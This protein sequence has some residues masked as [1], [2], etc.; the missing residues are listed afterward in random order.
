MPETH[1]RNMLNAMQ[2]GGGGGGKII[3][4]LSEGKL[5]I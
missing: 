1:S 5:R 4:H 2:P 3:L